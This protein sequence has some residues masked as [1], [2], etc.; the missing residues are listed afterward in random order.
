MSRERESRG[1]RLPAG[2]KDQQRLERLELRVL[3]LERRLG[4][5]PAESANYAPARAVIAQIHETTDAGA[6]AAEGVDGEP[7]VEATAERSA[8]I[9]KALALK[10]AGPNGKPASR[11]VLE[12]WKTD[13]LSSAIA[14]AEKA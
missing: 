8:L 7:I 3:E 13:R 12:R 1:F 14:E 2:I 10:I 9:D 5:D 11:S 6:E 4:L